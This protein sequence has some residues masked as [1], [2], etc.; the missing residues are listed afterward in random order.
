MEKEKAA[1]WG[2]R[3]FF[4]ISKR[5]LMEHKF[6]SVNFVDFLCMIIV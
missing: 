1:I 6:Y 5:V 4:S 3:S 2:R